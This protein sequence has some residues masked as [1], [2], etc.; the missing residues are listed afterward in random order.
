MY[1]KC[2]FKEKYAEDRSTMKRKKKKNKAYKKID[3]KTK[4][5]KDET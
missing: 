1:V 3:T 2:F 4:P 5:I